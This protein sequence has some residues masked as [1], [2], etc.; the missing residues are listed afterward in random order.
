MRA[1]GLF[2]SQGLIY[3]F[4]GNLDIITVLQLIMASD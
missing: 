1:K 4:I 3:D 2:S